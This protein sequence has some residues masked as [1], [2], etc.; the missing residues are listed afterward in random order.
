MKRVLVTGGARS[1]KSRLAEQMVLEMGQ[2]A[3]YI[4]TAQA[5]DQE[6]E[7][8]IASHQARRGDEWTTISEPIDLIGALKLAHPGQPILV[9]CLT[10]WLSNLMLSGADWEA[11]AKAM[12]AALPQIASPVVFVTNEVGA[13]IVPEN[14]LAREFRDAAGSLN[15]R[16]ASACDEVWLSVSGCPL[17]VKP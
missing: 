2:R 11:A 3:S 1:G 14:T 12:I 15:Q 16:V 17:R 8:R 10:L 5:F 4:A 7:D 6:M 9:D 13:G